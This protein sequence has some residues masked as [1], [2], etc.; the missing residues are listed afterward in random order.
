MTAEVIIDYSLYATYVVFGIAMLLTIIFPVI[1]MIGNFKKAIGMLIGLGVLVLVFM[2]CYFSATGE[3]YIRGDAYASA[4]MMK[5]VEA[6]LY[7]AYVM[8]ACTVLAIIVTSFSRYV[9]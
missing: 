3:E 6:S 1:Q 2:I 5:I 4:E 7:L 9:K 8:F